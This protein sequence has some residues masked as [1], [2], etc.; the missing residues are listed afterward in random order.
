MIYGYAR[1]STLGQAKGNSLEEQER[2]LKEAGAT[3][4]YK[5]SYT[6][7]KIDRP[8]L[9][10]LLGELKAGD[11]F[12]VTKLDRIARS[13]KEGIELFDSLI[14]RGIKVNVLNIG[15]MDDSPAGRLIRNVFL[16]FAEFERDMI[17][18]RTMEGKM[19]AR[20]RPD[21]REGRP[22]IEVDLTEQYNLV[23]RG[24]KTVT[25]VCKELGISRGTWYNRVKGMSECLKA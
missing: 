17:V 21:Y 1:V 12:M 6:G 23:Q 25:E 24:D 13:V 2:A 20:E 9:S 7:T 15:V 10:R 18:Q 16:S 5:D 22:R 19:I 11:T 3:K 4:I 8:S 14:E